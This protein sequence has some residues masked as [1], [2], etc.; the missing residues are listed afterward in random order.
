MQACSTY[1]DVNLILRLYDMR[2]ETRMRE[3]RDWFA[4]SFHARTLDEFR[5]LCPPGSPENASFRQVTTYWEMVASFVTSDV[6]QKEVFFKS[7]RELLFVWVRLEALVPLMRDAYKDQTQFGN[8]EEV[9][10][11]YVAWWESEAPGAYEAFRGRIS[12]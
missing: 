11:E 12:A 1:D 10:G 5:K 7:G 3:A 6:L 2:R 4:S 9:A 8:L